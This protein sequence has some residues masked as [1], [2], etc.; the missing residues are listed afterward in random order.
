MKGLDWIAVASDIAFDDD[1]EYASDAAF[2]TYIELLGISAYRLSDGRVAQR[3]AQ[4]LCNTRYLARALKELSLQE[5]IYADGGDI[6]LIKYAKW[7]KTRAEVESSRSKTN[8]RVRRCR[9]DSNTVTPPAANA[10][11]VE[12][13]K[14]RVRERDNTIIGRGK[15]EATS[16]VDNSAEKD[17]LVAFALL[18]LPPSDSTAED[19]RRTIDR[20]RVK[21]TDEHIE[22]I[23]AQLGN[24]QPKK[25]Y[26]PRLHLTLASWLN[27]EPRDAQP[28]SLV[29]WVTPAEDP[30]DPFVPM[31]PEIAEMIRNIGMT[32]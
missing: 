3:D 24:W 26:G 21:L 12:K 14:S 2:R 1:L 11:R 29:P 15:E 28:P 30:D 27:K 9:G 8:T 4:K 17:A 22:R 16:P 32:L 13:S 5:R 6:V 31:P 18:E 10:A 20:Y 23:I 7:Q 25:P 19:Y